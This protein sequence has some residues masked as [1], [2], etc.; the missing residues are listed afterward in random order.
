MLSLQKELEETA[1][2]LL[3]TQKDQQQSQSTS[4][5]TLQECKRLQIALESEVASHSTTKDNLLEVQNK[6][7]IIH[8]EKLE[9]FQ[10][11][12]DTNNSSNVAIL[13]QR[14]KEVASLREQTIDQAEQIE[15]KTIIL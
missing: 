9:S 13:Q 1:Q 11:D 4:D 5:I 15:V 3:K 10:A 2:L 7:K 12:T 14:Q 6:L 8:T